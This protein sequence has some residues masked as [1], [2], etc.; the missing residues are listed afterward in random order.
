MHSKGRLHI[1]SVKPLG[2]LI[3]H[4]VNRS[5]LKELLLLVLAELDTAPTKNRS[6]VGFR[7]RLQMKEVAKKGNGRGDAMESFTEMNKNK[8][9]KNPI[10]GK[11]VQGNIKITK[12]SMKKRRSWKA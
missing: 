1:T 9:V 10:W 7:V 11:M 12:E 2:S 3:F 5:I 4:R 8:E 6:I